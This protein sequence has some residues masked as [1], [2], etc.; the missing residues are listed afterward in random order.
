MD[1]AHRQ[2]QININAHVI[3]DTLE[4]IAVLLM[5]YVVQIHVLKD[6]VHNLNLAHINAIVNVVTLEQIVML[7]LINV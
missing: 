6:L 4:L 3:L 7:K 2:A 5:T 1:N